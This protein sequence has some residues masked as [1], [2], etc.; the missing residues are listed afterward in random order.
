MF[1]LHNFQLL[2]EKEFSLSYT[3]RAFQYNDG[4][5]DTLIM[6]QGC[7]RFLPDH[8]ERIQQAIQV[9][10][11][12]LP[13]ELQNPEILEKHLQRLAQQNQLQNQ[14]ARVKVHLWRAPGGLFT[15]EQHAAQSLITIH[16]QSTY[17]KIIRHVDFATTVHT[18][19]S[20]LSF[21][22]GPYAAHYVLASLEKKQKQ[23]DELL[24]LD[25]NGH[26]AESLTANIFWIKENELYTP[27][28]TT[29]CIAGIVR[30]NILKISHAG[31]M[32]IR[33]GHFLPNNLL[34]SETVF[35]SNVTG[36]RPIQHIGQTTF[37]TSHPLV[38]Q[39]Y[40]L[41]FEDKS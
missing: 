34:T 25:G 2:P 21:F 39:L 16:P 27:A 6:D 7:I 26:V 33:E 20:A 9:W 5:F 12:T 11:L 30:K 15:P 23:L 40:V 17:D 29:G 36:L 10:Q 37:C 28:L 32:T 41:L 4:L 22:K 1:V 13:A 31:N 19:Y 38:D 35:T 14:L 24:L 18:S 8:L 3:N